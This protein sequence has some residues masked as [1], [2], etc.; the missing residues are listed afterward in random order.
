MENGNRRL[1]SE[2]RQLL[3]NI[4]AS[5]GRTA[6]ERLGVGYDRVSADY[7]RG[8]LE[9]VARQASDENVLMVYFLTKLAE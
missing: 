4:A 6:D 1:S 8:Y 7:A 5:I 2:N 3:A 9:G